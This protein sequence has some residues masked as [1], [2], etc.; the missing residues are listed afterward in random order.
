MPLGQNFADHA[1]DEARCADNADIELA[2]GGETMNHDATPSYGGEQCG[3]S[4]GPKGKPRLLVAGRVVWVPQ[5][6]TATTVP[7]LAVGLVVM[8][9]VGILDM[10]RASNHAAPQCKWL[11]CVA[12]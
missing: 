2:P 12:M 4:D 11:C 10:E 5:P 3:G 1:A 7:A 8:V 9:M 6:S